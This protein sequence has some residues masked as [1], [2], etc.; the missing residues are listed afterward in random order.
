MVDL[1]QRCNNACRKFAYEKTII[2]ADD[3]GYNCLD[4][5]NDDAVRGVG[6]DQIESEVDKGSADPIHSPSSA[7]RAFLNCDHR[8]QS[9]NGQEDK[10]RDKVCKMSQKAPIGP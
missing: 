3:N 7:K 2:D 10:K 8:F 4:Y 9:R 5:R 6:S 1:E